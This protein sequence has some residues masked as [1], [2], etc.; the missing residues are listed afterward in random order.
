MSERQSEP[1]LVVVPDH[2]T[3]PPSSLHPDD[4]TGKELHKFD[5]LIKGL[6]ALADQ[7]AHLAASLPELREDIASLCSMKVDIHRILD[8]IQEAVNAGIEAAAGYG[9][10]KY[11]QSQQQA[12]IER[13]DH[14]IGEL[15][16]MISSIP[17]VSGKPCPPAHN[18]TI[19]APSSGV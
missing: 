19:P 9:E 2:D 14:E 10:M 1:D 6:P 12:K 17:C 3:L 13:Q 7:V 18:S 15:K 8:L 5:D 16:K 11:I 4:D